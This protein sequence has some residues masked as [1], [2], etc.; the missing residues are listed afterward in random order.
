METRQLCR[1][2]RLLTNH[3]NG[4]GWQ[5][6]TDKWE[7]RFGQILHDALSTTLW[8]REVSRTTQNKLEVSIM[9]AAHLIFADDPNIVHVVNEQC[10]LATLLVQGWHRYAHPQLRHLYK[11]VVET[12]KEHTV[13]FQPADYLPV[14]VANVVQPLEM[15]LR[16][17]GVLTTGDGRRQVILDWKTTSRPSTDWE[18]NLQNSLQTHLYIAATEQLL[19]GSGK[20]VDGVV[21]H[22]LVKGKREID[23]AKSSPFCG[24]FIQYGS[25]LYAW[26]KAG[27]ISATYTTGSARVYLPATVEWQAAYRDGFDELFIYLETIFNMREYFPTTLPFRPLNVGETVGQQIIAEHE[28][29]TV[30]AYYEQMPPTERWRYE[31]V[32]FEQTLSACHKYGTKHACPFVEYCTGNWDAEDLANNYQPR[33]DHHAPPAGE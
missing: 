20:Y 11:H 1:R 9:D 26:E 23:R 32:L 12:E 28:F 24:Q 15:P 16:R 30:L 29:A 7:P 2:K 18:V 10:W 3:H 17:D 33:E 8:E 25:F 5:P 22:G 19:I 4:H 14:N 21:Y 6:A 27:K 13:V 31:S